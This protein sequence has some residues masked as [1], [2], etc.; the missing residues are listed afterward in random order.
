MLK[1]VT[2]KNEAVKNELVRLKSSSGVCVISSNSSV[3][4]RCPQ[5][6]QEPGGQRGFAALGLWRGAFLDRIIPGCWGQG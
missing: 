1:Q 2:D 6:L 4:P 5:E 3:C